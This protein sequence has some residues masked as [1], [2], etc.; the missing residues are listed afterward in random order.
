[1]RLADILLDSVSIAK[2]QTECSGQVRQGVWFRPL[3]FLRDAAVTL[4][5]PGQCQ[6][7]VGKETLSFRTFLCYLLLF[8]LSS[9]AS[10]CLA[11]SQPSGSFLTCACVTGGRRSVVVFRLKGHRVSGHGVFHPE[12]EVQ[13]GHLPARLPP[14]HHVHAVVDRHQMG[15]RGTV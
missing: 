5:K 9:P 12:E 13:P 14:L 2:R 8:F 3:S 15:G 10:G 1:M 4:A 6:V 7:T 11:S